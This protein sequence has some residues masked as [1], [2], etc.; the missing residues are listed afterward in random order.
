MTFPELHMAVV[1][2]SNEE[3]RESSHAFDGI[4]NQIAKSLDPGSVALF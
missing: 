4:A 3:D 1:V 2:L